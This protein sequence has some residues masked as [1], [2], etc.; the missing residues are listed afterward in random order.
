MEE[1]L[2]EKERCAVYH[3]DPLQTSCGDAKP[4]LLGE[5]SDGIG[6]SQEHELASAMDQ[7]HQEAQTRPEQVDIEEVKR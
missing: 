3:V 2:G 6:S 4:S 1:P 7:E 5:P